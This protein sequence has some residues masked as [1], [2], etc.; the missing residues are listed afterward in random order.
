[1]N[2]IFKFLSIAK[3][4]G[5]KIAFAQVKQSI[6]TGN[7]KQLATY[8]KDEK[9][10]SW[11][12]KHYGYVIDKY[13]AMNIHPSGKIESDSPIWVFW[14]QGISFAPDIVRMC[15]KS[16]EKNSGK[17][18]VIII[19]K[20]NIEN[21]VSFP[22]YIFDKVKNG[23]ITLTHFSDILRFSLLSSYGGIWI[24]STVFTF[25]NE[26]AFNFE[27]YCLYTLRTEFNPNYDIAK[28]KWV[29]YFFAVSG[30]GK[31][32]A[33]YMVEFFLE[34]WK[35]NTMLIDYL[36]VDC[37]IALAYENIP[38][39]KN[40]IESVPPNNQGVYN[41]FEHMND[42]FSELLLNK[43]AE[44]VFNKLSYKTEYKSEINGSPTIYTKL[45]ERELNER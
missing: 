10:K 16:I 22:Q 40:M 37:A 25:D 45:M 12:K 3:N 26:K 43:L 15:V 32:F 29:S 14:Y 2:K 6:S 17:H 9:V 36:L 4:F 1:M 41:L 19:D 7:K 20:N 35:N 27:K 28:G 31:I 11:L 5:L 33:Q 21:Y 38:W 30:S 13:A 42:L 24:D 34:Y 44:N 8:R 23:N 39:V 18:P